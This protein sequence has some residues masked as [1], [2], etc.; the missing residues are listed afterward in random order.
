MDILTRYDH[1][2]DE[3][4]E[5]ALDELVRHTLLLEG[6]ADNTEVSLSFV[7]EETMTSLNMQYRGLEGPTD[8]LSFECDDIELGLEANDGCEDTRILGDI[9]IAPDVARA[10]APLFG[11]TLQ[12]EIELLVVHGTLHLCGYDH[13]D[14]DEAETMENREAEILEAWYAKR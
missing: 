2:E 4:A 8:V 6:T 9:I 11:T 14:D 1:C 10:Q 5:M 12:E 13:I 3:L 7:D